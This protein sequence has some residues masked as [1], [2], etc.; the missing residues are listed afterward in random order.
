M[1]VDLCAHQS[2]YSVFSTSKSLKLESRRLLDKMNAVGMT[3]YTIFH[4]EQLA[5]KG[6]AQILCA[7]HDGHNFIL[8]G[9]GHQK[10]E[11]VI[12][13]PLGR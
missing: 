4:T 9:S 13:D 1:H 5:S 7:F 12:V 11:S 2:I 6:V 8:R 10:N 3:S